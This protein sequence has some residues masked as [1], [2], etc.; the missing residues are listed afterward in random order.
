[1]EI[2]FPALTSVLAKSPLNFRLGY[3]QGTRYFLSSITNIQPFFEK[4]KSKC[5]KNRFFLGNVD[6]ST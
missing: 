2:C 6:F 4:T 5:K 1:M 3:C